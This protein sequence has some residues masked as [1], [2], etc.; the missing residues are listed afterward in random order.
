MPRGGRRDGAGAKYKWAYGETKVIRVPI[1]L[2]D[3]ILEIA[4]L[5]DQGIPLETVTQ[6]KVVDL[7]G[8][9]VQSTEKGLVV[10]LQ[11]L[12]NAGYKI[13]PAALASDIRKSIDKRNIG[14]WQK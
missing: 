14:K 7:S 11:D 6:S 12:L 8:I 4:K 13:R 1:A 5:L 9:S 2:A 10:N 3:R